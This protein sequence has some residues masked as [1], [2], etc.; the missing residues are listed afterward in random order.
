VSRGGRQ[1][2]WT[3]LAVGTAVR[4]LVMAL[5]SG[6]PYDMGSFQIV[7]AALHDH[8]LDTYSVVNT[9]GQFHWPYPPAFFPW[10]LVAGHFAGTV[11]LSFAD[12]VRLPSI[13]ADAAIAWL[14]QD[15]LGRRGATERRRLVAAGLVALG[16]SFIIIS[17]YH[18]HIDSL[19]ILPAVGA[20]WL[21]EHG[22]IGRR[23]LLAGLLIGFGAALKTVPGL[24][25]IALLPTVRSWRE[26]GTLIGA[27]VAVPLATL[28]PFFLSD[29][30]GVRHLAD[31][32]GVPGAGGLTLLVQPDLARAL[33][34]KPPPFS[35][36]TQTLLDHQGLVN[37]VVLGAVAVLVFVRR[38]S[39]TR[40]AVLV[41]LAVWAFGTGFLFQYLV[42]GLPFLLLDDHLVA[43]GALQI[44]ALFAAL[45]FYLAPWHSEAIVVV[46]VA[47]MLA[48]W[49]AWVG[50]LVGLGR[51]TMRAPPSPRV[52]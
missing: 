35:G 44:V 16:P 52:A 8:G 9:G 19:A 21:W 40:A 4:L 28:V 23:A 26:A 33:L 5:T 17:G 31:Y 1:L 11:A 47:L 36:A 15:F 41:W 49:V 13:F 10:I 12:I 18:G 46:Y 30:A 20:L 34:A 32:G 3:L 6:Q 51:R 48:L 7:H 24:M 43:A 39:A 42:W 38:V 37:A 50:G 45:L 22:D 27:A 29:P 25:V 2:L 14:V